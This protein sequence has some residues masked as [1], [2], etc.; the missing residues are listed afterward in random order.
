MWPT[1]YCL[2]FRHCH[3]K[4]CW[5]E[6]TVLSTVTMKPTVFGSVTSYL[7]A[8]HT[9]LHV[10]IG[11]VVRGWSQGWSI[12]WNVGVPVPDYTISHHIR[13]VF[14]MTAVIE[15]SHFMQGMR[16]RRP[17]NSRPILSIG[18]NGN[19]G[20]CVFEALKTTRSVG[21]FCSQRYF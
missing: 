12:P 8:F 20:E 7:P 13:E 14:F 15:W 16:S 17:H 6:T 4:Q 21:N 3:N 1:H 11:I 5:Y 19:L 10:F 18:I 2:V 9:I